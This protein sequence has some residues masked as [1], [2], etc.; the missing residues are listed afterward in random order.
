MLRN[1]QHGAEPWDYVLARPMSAF[2]ES[3]R[4]V[5]ARLLLARSPGIGQ[6][7]CITSSVSNESKSV[8]SASLARAMALSGDRV[9]LIDCD[10]R[11]NGLAGLL[12]VQPIVGLVEVLNGDVHADD[13]IVGDIAHGL[14]IMPLAEA[15]F[16]PKDMFSGGAMADLLIYLRRHYD[17]IVMDTPPTL[18]VDDAVTLAT[19]ADKVLLAVRWGTT[20]R[21]A[22]R[23]TIARLRESGAEVFGI[24]LTGVSERGNLALAHSDPHYYLT[25]A[26]GYHR[27]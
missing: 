5:R 24:V 21:E 16:S 7:V 8:L 26:H 2:A 23:L 6:V 9:I 11:R 1:A 27:N 14:D 15:Q 12:T 19:L 20:R 17:F 18:I 10:L 22:L 4:S 13:A 25:T 3:L